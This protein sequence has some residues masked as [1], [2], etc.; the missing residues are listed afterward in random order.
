MENYIQDKKEF[1]EKWIV[2][3]DS[4]IRMRVLS[5]W[6]KENKKELKEFLEG[7]LK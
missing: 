1:I 6:E 4:D 5:D 7:L 3:L 2:W